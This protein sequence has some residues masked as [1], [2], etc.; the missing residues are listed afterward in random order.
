[1]CLVSRKVC[2]M[3]ENLGSDELTCLDVIDIQYINSSGGG[4][5][6]NVQVKKGT[7]AKQFIDQKLGEQQSGSVV[8][9]GYRIRVNGQTAEADKVLE[10]ACRVTVTPVKV[11]GGLC[12]V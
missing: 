7:T 6:Q 4:F 10:N 11:D 9:D 2:I 12:V 8:Y 1:M 5:A 3:D